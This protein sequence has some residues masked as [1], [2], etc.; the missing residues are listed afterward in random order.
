MALHTS[1]GWATLTFD[2]LGKPVGGG[3]CR[4]SGPTAY[5]AWRRQPRPGG[6]PPRFVL[7]TTRRRLA[8]QLARLRGDA[9]PRSKR[10]DLRPPD[11]RARR[12]NK[13]RGD[14]KQGDPPVH[15]AGPGSVR[16]ALRHRRSSA[17]VGARLPQPHRNPRQETP[18]TLR[19]P[20]PSKNLVQSTMNSSAAAIMVAC[21]R[22][23]RQTPAS[24]G[25]HDVVCRRRQ[26]NTRTDSFKNLVSSPPKTTR[27]RNCSL[28]F[29]RFR[30]AKVSR[31]YNVLK[32]VSVPMAITEKLATMLS[33][34][35]WCCLFLFA[36]KTTEEIF[37][38]AASLRKRFRKDEHERSAFTS[39]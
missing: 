15:S 19:P 8:A 35:S 34:T 10:S 28:A 4:E 31:I 7:I 24:G 39:L 17:L 25:N 5:A 14:E 26:T 16:A 6:M 12:T 20:P 22:R 23:R 33:A 21:R 36:S 11:Q 18:N 13:Q 29:S 2:L 3:V 27:L 37:T 9:A 38:A 30:F 32:M 1:C